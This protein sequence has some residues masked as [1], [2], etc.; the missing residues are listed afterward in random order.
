MASNFDSGFANAMKTFWHAM[1]SD[2]RHA[3]FDSPYRAASSYPGVGRNPELSSV[4]SSRLHNTPYQDEFGHPA[5]R[6]STHLASSAA[7]SNDIYSPRSTGGPLSPS[8]YSPGSRSSTTTRPKDGSAISGI[9]LQD[10][11]ADG[12][13]PPPPVAHSWTRIDTWA[14]DNYPELFDQLCEGSTVNDINELEHDLDCSLPMD[15]RES[16]QFHDGQ[17]RGGTPTGIIFGAML[18]DCEEILDEWK[19]WQVVRAEYLQRQNIAASK[20]HVGPSSGPSSPRGGAAPPNGSTLNRAVL[21][22]R[23]DSQPEG[24]VQKVYCH[25][26]WIPLVRDWGGNNIGID[27]APGP[28]G[29]WGQVIMFGRD[30][31]CKYVVAKSWASFLATVADDL[32]G[33]NWY[34]EEE[35]GELKLRELKTTKVEPGYFDILRLRTDKKYGRKIPP[36]MRRRPGPPPHVATGGNGPVGPRP[37]PGTSSPSSPMIGL[38]PIIR[39]DGSREPMPSKSLSPIHAPKAVRPIGRVLEEMP[40]STASNPGTPVILTPSRTSLQSSRSAETPPPLVIDNSVTKKKDDLEDLSDL[41][42]TPTTSKSGETE[43]IAPETKEPSKQVDYL[44][45]TLEEVDLGKSK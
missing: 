18:L 42:S 28:A 15:V 3:T 4:S 34:V 22:A 16:L 24:A 29:K 38:S 23:Q 35:S 7:E 45:D 27:L 43:K 17:E 19:Q 12:S 44:A 40:T 5:S 21:M 36:H 2:D 11:N 13:P 39:P 30:Y 8:P 1:T 9:P 20:P 32:D 31:D 6:S 14:E 25:P 37:G 10:F 26:G 41:I 33:N